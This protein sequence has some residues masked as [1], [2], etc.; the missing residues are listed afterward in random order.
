MLYKYGAFTLA[1]ADTFMFRQCKHSIEQFTQVLRCSQLNNQVS[2][3]A[4]YDTYCMNKMGKS[5]ATRILHCIF[6]CICDFGCFNWQEANKDR[7]VN[8][9]VPKVPFTLSHF[10]INGNV[11]LNVDYS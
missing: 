6:K 4:P 11:Q 2:F 9:N 7:N 8:T 5:I 1:A 10:T 3:K